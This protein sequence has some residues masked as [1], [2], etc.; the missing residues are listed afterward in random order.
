[1]ENLLSEQLAFTVSAANSRDSTLEDLACAL[2]GAGASPACAKYVIGKLAQAIDKHQVFCGAT[3]AAPRDIPAA[4]EA[5]Q[6]I[7]RPIVFG[8]LLEIALARLELFSS[9]NDPDGWP[10]C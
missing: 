1:M 4:I 5:A 2:T 8:L 10:A 7:F 3:I 9:E 6:D